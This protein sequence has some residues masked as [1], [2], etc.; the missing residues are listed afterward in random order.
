M[1]PDLC[2]CFNDL[3]MTQSHMQNGVYLV[4]GVGG[5]NANARPV[6]HEPEWPAFGTHIP[7]LTV[8][9]RVRPKLRHVN[10]HRRAVSI[11]V[12]D[13]FLTGFLMSILMNFAPTKAFLMIIFM[14]S[15]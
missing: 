8:L 5:Q 10:V 4:N 7:S 13:V 14:R 1:F 15:S 2:K 6:K 9:V 11:E 3:Q 12:M